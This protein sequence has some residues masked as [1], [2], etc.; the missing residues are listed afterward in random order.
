MDI[1]KYWSISVGALEVN[2]TLIT[3]VKNKTNKQ[4]KNFRNAGIMLAKHDV[5][6]EIGM[7]WKYSRHHSWISQYIILFG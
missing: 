2:V 4:K 3:A 1:I 5:K 7:A 6:N